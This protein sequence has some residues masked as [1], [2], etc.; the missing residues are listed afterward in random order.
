MGMKGKR[1]SG[2]QKKKSIKANV[3]SKFNSTRKLSRMGKKVKKV[4]QD[5]H[6]A[7]S[8]IRS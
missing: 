5:R 6:S 4:W 3:T 2:K 7:P 8:L 1:P